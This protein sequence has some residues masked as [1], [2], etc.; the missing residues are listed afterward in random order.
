MLEYHVL[1]ERQRNER[2]GYPSSLSVRIHRALSWLKQAEQATD[3]DTKFIFLWISFNA[4]Y[5]QDF[6]QKETYSERGMYQEFLSKLVEL[7]TKKN[8]SELVWQQ[9]SSKIRLILD[10]EY[11]LQDYWR[12]HSGLISESQWKQARDNAKSAA[13]QALSHNNTA[14]V[15]SIIFSRFYTLR[16]QLIHG[17][18]THSSSANRE[19]LKLCVSLLEQIVPVLIEL[20]MDGKGAL[21]GEPVYPLIES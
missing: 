9:Y 16:N 18:A 12:F 21:W 3:E 8:L 7:D 5:A 10:N 6:E 14:L 15:L 19:Q 1:K 2:S 17:G 20:M 11:I 13:N 4:A